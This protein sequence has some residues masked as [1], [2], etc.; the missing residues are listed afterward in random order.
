MG[1]DLGMHTPSLKIKDYNSWYILLASATSVWKQ[2]ELPTLKSEG[3]ITKL[4]S[5]TSTATSVTDAVG[6]LA[7]DSGAA[8]IA[9][10]A[11]EGA[12]DGLLADFADVLFV[13]IL[14]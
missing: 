5:L 14:W 11:T 6:T 2:Q 7:I 12:M 3:K 4:V 1:A 8:T 10:A 9:E 13:A